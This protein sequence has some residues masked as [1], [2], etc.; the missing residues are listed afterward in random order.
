WDSWQGRFPRDSRD[1]VQAG[2][3]FSIRDH[4]RNPRQALVFRID[5]P[6]CLR[7]RFAFLITAIPAMAAIPESPASPGS[8]PN[9]MLVWWGGS[10]M[11]A[12]RGEIPAILLA[13]GFSRRYDS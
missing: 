11:L 9:P 1:P 8:P 5:L 6:P 2:F 3:V 7:D 12:C 10:P 13:R 4:L